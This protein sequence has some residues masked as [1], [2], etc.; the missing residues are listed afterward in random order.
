MVLVSLKLF[1]RK[2]NTNKQILS[3][4]DSICIFQQYIQFLRSVGFPIIFGL[5]QVMQS[6]LIFLRALYSLIYIYMKTEEIY[7][8]GTVVKVHFVLR[9]VGY[10]IATILT[11]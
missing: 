2:M 6:M 9:P 3:L 5:F 8:F 11:M 4:F 7:Q 10:D 1:V